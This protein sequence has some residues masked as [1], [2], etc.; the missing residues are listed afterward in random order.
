MQWLSGR[1]GAERNYAFEVAAV[2]NVSFDVAGG[3]TVVILGRNGSGKS[4]LLQMIAGTL[5]P[6]AGYTSVEGRVTALLE[7]GTGFNPDYTGRENLRLNARIFGLTSDEIH[8]A[9][10]SIEAFADIGSFIDEPVRTY[11]SGMYVRLAFATAIHLIPDVLIVDEALAVGD[12]FFQ[13]KCIDYILT[14]MNHATKLIVTHDVSTAARLGD[15]VLVMDKGELI[16]DGHPLEGIEQFT[17]LNLGERAYSSHVSR[18][19]GLQSPLDA[20]VTLRPIEAEEGRISLPPDKSS[21]PELLLFESI[22]M[23]VSNASTGTGR[24]ISRPTL[25]PGDRLVLATEFSLNTS[26]EQPILGYLVRDRVGNVVFGQNTL[27]SGMRL[28]PLRPGRYQ[29]RLSLSWPELAEGEY[30]ITLGCGDG[31]HPLHHLILGWAQNVAT[32]VSAPRRPVHG[33]FNSDIT[34]VSIGRL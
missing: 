32:V 23:H 34:D 18:A 2:S 12:V 21:N 28:E 17:S 20:D 10:P 8:S 1:L 13:Q 26:I 33:F 27:G 30:L 7:L 5:T 19:E 6:T 24:W 11:S 16:F 15:R 29:V 31:I 22:S 4:T 25:S 14:R 9:E 3:E